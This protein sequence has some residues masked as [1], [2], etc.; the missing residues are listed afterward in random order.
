MAKRSVMRW[1]NSLALRIPAGIAEPLGIGERSQVTLEVM[2]GALV[3]RP[4]EA[5][6]E[7]SD[8]D[9]HRGLR[10]LAKARRRDRAS[11]SEFGRPVG[12]E[13]W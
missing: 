7:F 12:R 6:P 2:N 11:L 10:L 1:G 5:L 8:K 3:I 4:A 9:L 13:I